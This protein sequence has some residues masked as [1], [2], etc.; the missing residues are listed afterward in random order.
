[1]S[2]TR[3]ENKEKTKEKNSGTPKWVQVRLFPI[4]IRVGLII[5]LAGLSLMVG[6]MVGYGVIGDGT[7][8]DVLKKE[9][10]THIIDLVTKD[11]E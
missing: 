10:W 2:E 3:S 5:L 11:T 4:L 8:Q 7:P 1:M 9:T 6:L